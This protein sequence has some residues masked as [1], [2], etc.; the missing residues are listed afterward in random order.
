M[1]L[2]VTVLG[3]GTALQ[4]ATHGSAGFAVHVGDATL[5]VDGGSGTL[6]RAARAGVD[7]RTLRAGLSTH[8][9][10][11]HTG[12]LVPLMFSW[13]VGGRDRAHPNYPIYA[14]EGFTA[15]LDALRGVYGPWLH[16][17]ERVPI[18]ELPLDRPATCTLDAAGLPDVRLDTRPANHSAGALHLSLEAGGRRV[19]FSGDTAWSDALVEL[20]TGADL[21]VCE[22]AGSDHAPVP[23]HLRPSEVARILAAARPSAAWIHHLYPAV[24]PR[25]VAD[26][27]A[28]VGVPFHLAT[29]LDR[30]EGGVAPV[31]RRS[32]GD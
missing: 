26:V 30:W 29:D 21:L 8:R 31:A 10:V 27:L 6:Q 19:V 13:R 12:D 22:C 3:A 20:A 28:P 15:F 24:D 2:A 5:L 23:T 1:S 11:D 25:H 32:G 17:P 14:G 7:T 9:H 18:H 4:T 16:P